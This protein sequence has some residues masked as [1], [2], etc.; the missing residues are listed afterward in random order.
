[1]F[2]ITDNLNNN[3]NRDNTFLISIDA[4]IMFSSIHNEPGIKSFKHL[5]NARS[6]LNSPT[7]SILEALYICLECNNTIF[8]NKFYLQR[9]GTTQVSCMSCSYTEYQ[10]IL[11][12]RNYSPSFVAKKFIRAS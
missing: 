7:F 10:S 8:K 1:M 6:I 2:N 11:I 3:C 9:Y 12:A 4:V 5:V